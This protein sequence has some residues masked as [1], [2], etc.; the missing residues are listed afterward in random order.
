MEEEQFGRRLDPDVRPLPRRAGGL[1]PLRDSL[2]PDAHRDRHG[3]EHRGEPG[4]HPLGAAFPQGRVT[5][6]TATA[7]TAMILPSPPGADAYLAVVHRLDKETSGV[8]LLARNAEALRAAHAVWRRDVV[9][10]Y[11]AVTRGVPSPAEGRVGAPPLENRPAPRG[12]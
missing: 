12:P 4:G 6:R 11:L 8:L 1:P 2:P 9:K 7:R 10:T 5:A 3:G